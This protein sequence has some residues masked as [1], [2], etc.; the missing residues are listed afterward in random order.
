ME[1]RETY[2]VPNSPR[3]QLRV[4]RSCTLAIVSVSNA[5]P[6]LNSAEG[7]TLQR[8]DHSIGYV[9]RALIV[10]VPSEDAHRSV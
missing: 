7:P 1:L 5:M 4:V 10:S 2:I 9:A 6:F 8:H 3:L